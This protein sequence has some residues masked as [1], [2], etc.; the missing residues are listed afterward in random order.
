MV[1]F[2]VNREI[3]IN[4][5]ILYSPEWR[6]IEVRVRIPVEPAGN[7]D[8]C[9]QWAQE[10]ICRA[11][12]AGAGAPLKVRQ[13]ISRRP[14]RCLYNPSS[15]E[16]GSGAQNS[17]GSLELVNPLMLWDTLYWLHAS[18]GCSRLLSYLSHRG[19]MIDF[20]LKHVLPSPPAS[21]PWCR[22][23]LN[24]TSANP[25]SK[26]VS[27]VTSWM[28]EDLAVTVVQGKLTPPISAIFGYQSLLP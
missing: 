21:R 5:K 2:Y 22:I 27:A 14:W 3:Y 25:S 6:E 28:V 26:V 15:L 4:E 12:L 13:A 9:M 19:W 23:M 18:Y 11:R 17:P 20:F 10:G 7:H 24:I 16:G 8:L 1:S